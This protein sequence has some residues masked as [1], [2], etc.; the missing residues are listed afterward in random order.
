LIIVENPKDNNYVCQEK[1]LAPD[2]CRNCCAG[3]ERGSGRKEDLGVGEAALQDLTD[4]R[5]IA[6]ACDRDPASL[7]QEA[8]SRGHLVSDYLRSQESPEVYLQ[9][10]APRVGRYNGFS[11]FVRDRSGLCYYSNRGEAIRLASGIHGMSNPLLD[12]LWPKVSRGPEIQLTH[13]RILHILP[14]FLIAELT[15]LF[16]IT[17]IPPSSF[18]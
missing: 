5:P 3:R 8:P 14:S 7:K 1:T 18:Y 16:L 6:I 11:L 12:T 10:L 4:L 9:R 2:G 15:I 17:Y 13:K